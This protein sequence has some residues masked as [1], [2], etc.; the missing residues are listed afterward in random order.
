MA[1][2]K[3]CQTARVGRPKLCAVAGS[4]E[5]EIVNS[6]KVE[7]VALIQCRRLGFKR[8][9]IPPFSKSTWQTET[10]Y[11]LYT[12]THTHTHTPTPHVHV[13]ACNDI[14]NNILCSISIVYLPPRSL[15]TRI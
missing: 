5:I 12:Q 4:K 8:H 14:H 6:P 15:L 9:G 7:A 13:Y 11:N 2:E 3:I 1:E 10:I